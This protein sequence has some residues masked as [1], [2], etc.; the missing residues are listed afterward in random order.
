MQR[1]LKILLPLLAA[2]LLHASWGG[3]QAQTPEGIRPYKIIGIAEDDPRF[4]PTDD[5]VYAAWRRVERNA[6]GLRWEGTVLVVFLESEADYLRETGTRPEHFAAAAAPARQTVWINPAAWSRDSARERVQVLAHEFVHILLHDLPGGRDLPLWAEEGIAM[7]LANQWS[8][9]DLADFARARLFGTVPAL[10]ELERA[11]PQDASTAMAYTVAYHA[12]GEMS[13]EYSPGPERV[14][15]LVNKLADPRQGPAISR[16]LRDPLRRD[17]YDDAVVD[18][19]GGWAT[20]G[21][22]A[23]SSGS[24][25][26]VFAAFLTIAAFFVLRQRRAAAL[27]RE[28]QE[29]PWAESLTRQD[30]EDIYGEP[31]G[32]WDTDDKPAP[33]RKNPWPEAE[34]K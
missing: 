20:I 16:S 23:L 11:F 27:R 4:H 32:K 6:A 12:V 10:A 21:V 3:A 5:L 25:L 1:L 31:E 19:L 14:A 9:I 7:R 30:I 2:L 24:S 13:K 34:D 18:A 26:I 28:R 8:P 17:A 33:A 22:I 29:E 15:V